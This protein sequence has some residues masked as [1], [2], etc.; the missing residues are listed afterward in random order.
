MN[1]LRRLARMVFSRNTLRFFR[2]GGM[3]LDYAKEIGDGT[4]TS[5]V[6]ATLA[7]VARNFPEAPPA[8]WPNEPGKPT[9]RPVDDHP[10]LRLLERPNPHFTGVLLWMATVVDWLATGN[11]YW[12]KERARGG[13]QPQRLWWLPS[14]QVCPESDDPRQLVTHYVYT[15][16][17][18]PYELRLDEVVHFRYGADPLNPKVGLSPL[19]TVLKE[20]F[21]DEE[22]ASFTASILRNMGVPGILVSPDGDNVELS[23]EDALEAKAALKA[24]VAGESRGEPLVVTSKTKLQQFGFSPEQLV[25]RDLR[26]IPEERVT[27][28]IGIPAVVVGFG[29]GLK[30]STF[31][32]M[33]EAREMAYEAGL[34]PM[35]RILGEEIRW[36]LL[37]DYESDPYLWRCG[38]DLS[39]VRVLQEDFYR[40]MQRLDVGIRGGWIQVSEGREAAGYDSGDADRIYLRQGNLI[41]VPADGGQPRV[42]APSSNGNGNNGN[43]A[44]ADAAGIAREVVE[45]M[46]RREHV[47]LPTSRGGKT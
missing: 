19:A 40:Q 42:L 17:G 15:V 41:E 22:A 39:Q 28:A 38:F 14:W 23:E 21:T 32:N 16:D 11:A 1:R 24:Q 33:G 26:E 29:A 20:V 45:L 13:S 37:T 9:P 43:G 3:R 44:H 5:L 34:I 18:E 27:A 31:T 25:L 36:Q 7:W 12:W 6:G 35:Q 47:A 46:E 2:L 4:G 30:R 10:M 8:L